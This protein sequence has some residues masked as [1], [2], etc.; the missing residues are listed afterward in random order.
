MKDEKMNCFE[1][2]YK[3][4]FLKKINKQPVLKFN[5]FKGDS[6]QL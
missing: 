6:N 4:D 5:Q 1:I 2:D 3:L